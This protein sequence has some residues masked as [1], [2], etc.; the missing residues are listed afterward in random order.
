MYTAAA[1]AAGAG[2]IAVFRGRQRELRHKLGIHPKPVFDGN[3]DRAFGVP[4]QPLFF[5]HATE[6]DTWVAAPAYT[7]GGDFPCN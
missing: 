6:S 7:D 5:A 2:S 3:N 4:M 1:V